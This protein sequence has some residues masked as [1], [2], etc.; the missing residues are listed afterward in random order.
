MNT[1]KHEQIRIPQPLDR[2]RMERRYK[3]N[4]K[5]VTYQA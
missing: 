4:I 1:V 3:G 5:M 2:C